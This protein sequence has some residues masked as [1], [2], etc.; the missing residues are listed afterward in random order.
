MSNLIWKVDKTVP[1]QCPDFV[2]DPYTGEYPTTSCLV[3][4]CKTITEE[5]SQ[6][7]DTKE[8]AVKFAD[9]APL[10]CYEFKLDGILLKDK[11]DRSKE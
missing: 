10:S 8:N 11:R 7:F 4:H 3:Y 9:K 6:E 2:Q 5:R 1:T